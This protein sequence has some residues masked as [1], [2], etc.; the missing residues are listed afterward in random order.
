MQ[1]TCLITA[2]ILMTVFVSACAPKLYQKNSVAPN[3]TFNL[4]VASD[5]TD[6]KNDIHDRV[7]AHY[8]NLGN[9]DNTTIDKIHLFNSDQYDV[10]L[11]M[12]SCMARAGFNRS[13]K[14]YLNSN[15]SA[16]KIV[17]VVTAGDPDWQFSY[18]GIDAITSASV[19]ENKDKIFTL[20]TL[21]I[22]QILSKK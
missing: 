19:T 20:V 22:D 10:I 14:S 3:A 15:V 1:K 9:I 4:L 11:I 16:Q 2:F 18:S 7:I 17:L 13:L 5:G 8:K 6:F 12:D 21:Q